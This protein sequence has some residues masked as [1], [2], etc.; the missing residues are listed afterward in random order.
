MMRYDVRPSQYAVLVL[1]RANPGMSQA[2][3][4]GCLRIK[5]ANL[6]TL[7]DRLEQRGWTERGKAGNDR[8]ASVLNLTRSG[9]LLVRKIEAAH[10]RMERKLA[11]RL[12]DKRT[13]TLL[14]LLHDF[15]Q[16]ET[17]KN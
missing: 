16:A 9:Q 2:S 13:K 8:R 14:R 3:A 5:K 6:V 12:G 10:A 17:G 11:A 15:C 1:I 4:C 7:L